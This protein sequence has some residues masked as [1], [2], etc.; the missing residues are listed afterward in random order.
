MDIAIKIDSGVIHVE[1]V[2]KLF[3]CHFIAS[4]SKLKSSQ[5]LEGFQLPSKSPTN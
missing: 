4:E 3:Y 1:I 5:N 2:H